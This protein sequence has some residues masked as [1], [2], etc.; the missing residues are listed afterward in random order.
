MAKASSILEHFQ[1]YHIHRPMYEK[2]NN[3]IVE[4]KF[5][6]MFVTAVFGKINV[7][8]GVIY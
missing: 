2:V 1:I 3:E 4:A 5:K 8:T 7:K 6:G